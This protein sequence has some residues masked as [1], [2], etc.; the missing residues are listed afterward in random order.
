MENITVIILLLFGI[1]FLGILSY[2]YKFPLPIMLVI[3]GVLISV[4]PG[5]PVVALSPEIVFILFLPPLLYEAAW[6]TSWHEFKSAIRPI[7]LAAI[8]LV[9]FTTV[10][11][12]V[13]AHALI[14]NMSWPLAFLL[15]AIVS[16]PDAV[17]A[18]SVTKGLKLQPRMITILEGESL[19]N[20][21]SAL[22]CYR[23]ALT[24]I[25][26]GNFVLWEAGSIF[27]L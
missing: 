20:D 8:G 16:P 6:N 17:A 25:T 27:Y 4:I 11:V 10:S 1:S 3:C 13:V 2:R 7:G 26:A 22:I 24:A 23:Y 5:L 21:A 19:V 12:G 14:D 18:T 9:I 15:G